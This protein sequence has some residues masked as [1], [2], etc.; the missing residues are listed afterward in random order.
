[1]LF[2]SSN[3]QF[4]SQFSLILACLS[5]L[6]CTGI[7]LCISKFFSIKKWSRLEI[8]EI[9]DIYDIY[10]ILV[11]DI[12]V[13][14]HS[15]ATK[16]LEMAMSKPEH[17]KVKLQRETESSSWAG[18]IQ[19]PSLL[20]TFFSKNTRTIFPHIKHC[21]SCSID[22]TVTLCSPNQCC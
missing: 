12:L 1:M 10:E 8:Y 20:H 17:T 2:T 5:V 4:S 14:T 15:F 21:S 7:C 13:T 18:R 16:I 22:T 11:L 6:V 19:T 3:R 9:Y